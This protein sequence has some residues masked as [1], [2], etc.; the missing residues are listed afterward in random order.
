V[1]DIFAARPG[2]RV[3]SMFA[4]SLALVTVT[5]EAWAGSLEDGKNVG[6]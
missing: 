1:P 5:R 3:M 6:A 4:T 2:T